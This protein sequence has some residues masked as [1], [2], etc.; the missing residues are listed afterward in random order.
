MAIVGPIR[1]PKRGTPAKATP[2]GREGMSA[3]KP[4]S[5]RK[6]NVPLQVEVTSELTRVVAP[7]AKPAST[8]RTKSA[9][10]FSST[11]PVAPETLALLKADANNA[12]QPATAIG[13]CSP[14]SQPTTMTAAAS[15]PKTPAPLSAAKKRA[16]AD[17]DED[18][19]KVGRDAFA[20]LFT[21]AADW[22]CHAPERQLV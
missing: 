18:L 20:R 17:D 21:V 13:P 19:A 12:N 6:E 15:K 14:A 8:N 5:A 2:Y 4:V 1:T 3:P 16:A 7:E 10:R 22:W 9:R 11:M